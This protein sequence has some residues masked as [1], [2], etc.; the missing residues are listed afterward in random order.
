ME[1][2]ELLEKLEEVEACEEYKGSYN[3]RCPSCKANS[4]ITYISDGKIR[5]Y[6]AIGCSE[7][8]ICKALGINE[9]DLM[10][11][12]RKKLAIISARELQQKEF[13]PM[14][15]IVKDF[16]PKGLGIIAAASKIGKSWLVLDMC[17]Q[18]ASGRRF[19]NH[20][21]EQGEC[22]YLALEDTQRRLQDRMNK[23]LNGEEAPEGFFY[24][25][26]S[27]NIDDGLLEEL[28]VQMEA[29]P[30]TSLIVIDTLEKVRPSASGKD[31]A[32]S[33]DYKDVGALKEFADEY[34][35]CVLL[36]H[37]IR[38]MTDE[39]DPF[40]RISGT[41]AIM[42]AADT[43]LL[44]T[45]ENRDSEEATLTITGRDVESE[46]TVIKFS[47][48]TFRWEVVGNAS[49]LKEQRERL[50][51][52]AN[53][54]VK[55]IKSLLY[56]PPNIWSGT[57]TDLLNQCRRVSG[58]MVAPDGKGMTAKVKKL[59]SDLMRFDKIDYKPKSNGT[60]G[61]IHI[62]QYCDGNHWTDI[63][64]ECITDVFNYSNDNDDNAK[65]K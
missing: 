50:E 33:K 15:Y 52:D 30:D 38:K 25:T 29:H 3:S 49:W 22:L 24:A 37:H 32:Y 12:K 39:S 5:P 16:M 53:P 54:I 34:D 35:I 13:A 46:S 11:D 14:D 40:N 45:K 56:E 8:D 2:N 21:T 59:A 58:E 60:A 17:L 26:S 55:T 28:E 61:R 64:Q 23:I 57:A 4:M 47:K 48:D 51:Y 1:L 65:I 44:I 10:I 6:C 41:N 18:V 19:L 27:H 31:S 20:A 43:I 9:K 63:T 62:F 36:V 7:S 42:G